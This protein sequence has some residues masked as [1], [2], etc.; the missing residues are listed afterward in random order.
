MI[1]VVL[2]RLWHLFFIL[3]G[4]SFL[5]FLL[6]SLTPGDFLTSL[7][8]NPEIPPPTIDKLRIDFGLDKPFY[9][10]Y[11][12]WL[13][14]ISPIGFELDRPLFF[15][16][17]T[18]NLGYSFSY[19]IKVTQLIFPRFLNTILLSF[20]AEL[21]IW[22]IAIPA[23]LL[24]A[25]KK[26][27]FLDKIISFTAFVGLA[28]PE[29]LL[30]LLALLLAAKTG[31]FPIGGMTSSNFDDLSISGKVLDII[32]HLILPALVLAFANIATIIR[33]ARGA[34]LEAMDKQFVL[35]F[36]A[37]G[38][39]YKTILFKHIFRNALNP[40]ITLLGFSFGNLVSSS[41]I[42]EVIMS[43]PGIGLLTFESIFAKDLFV[44]NASVLLATLFLVVGNLLADISLI[45]IDPRIRYQNH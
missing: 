39:P 40:I 29:I 32:H 36:R 22:I 11:L 25:I 44:I 20:T 26:N 10:Q 43:W 45:L 5:S 13:Y 9:I 17:K 27:R 41:F 42:I 15:F 35:S 14:N 18:P 23:G 12:K 24:C 16:L 38:L 31:L 30:G 4:V 1:K 19:K 33:Y 34:F 21:I 2:N 7:S 8:L 6:I 28:F 3:L 37:K